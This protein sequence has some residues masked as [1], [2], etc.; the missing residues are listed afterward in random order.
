MRIKKIVLML[1][2]I[3]V[4]LSASAVLA[5]DDFVYT[6]EMMGL[7]M[8]ARALGMG[9]AHIAVADDASVIYYNPAGLARID[10]FSIVS[11]YTNQYGAVGFLTL[12]AATRNFGAGLL[13]LNASGIEETGEYGDQLGT[14]S[15]GETTAIVGYGRSIAPGFSLGG[16]LKY[17][18]QELPGNKGTGFTADV[19]ILIS[20][21]EGNVE[22]GAVGRNLFG[23]VNYASGMKDAFDRSFGLGLSF[24]PI[25]TLLIAVDALLANGFSA[26]LGAEYMFN[27]IAIRA[28]GSFGDES[29]LTVGAGFAVTN[30][31]IDYAYQYHNILPDSHRLSLKFRF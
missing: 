30:F 24:R 1:T 18:G 4:L 25:D 26:K 13:K 2:L 16:S 28:G 10:G 21:P 29:S 9:G 5:N 14:F 31:N 17:Y 12:G 22:I 23:A 7:G 19:G 20:V 11:L 6:A 3:F 15:V 8:G 27:S